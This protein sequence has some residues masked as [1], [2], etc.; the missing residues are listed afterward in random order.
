[1][2]D[3]SNASAA[4]LQKPENFKFDFIPVKKHNLMIEW[5]Y[6]EFQSICPVSG[7]HDQGT[8][9]LRYRPREKLLESKSMREYLSMW[10]NLHNWQ[11]QITEEIADAVYKVLEPAALEVKIEWA[12]RG[13]IFARTI[14]KKGGEI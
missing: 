7:R 9:T 2:T 4:E 14:S 13:G 11:E 3:Y 5:A 8:L 6:P 12:P 1:M 10:R